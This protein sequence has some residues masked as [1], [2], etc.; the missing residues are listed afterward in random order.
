MYKGAAAEQGGREELSLDWQPGS[1]CFVAIG[2]KAV[3]P[4]W[5]IFSFIIR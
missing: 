4:G 1:F 3:D 5:I 2:I